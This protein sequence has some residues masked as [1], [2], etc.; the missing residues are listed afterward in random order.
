MNG[1][2]TL[3]WGIN[4]LVGGWLLA[5]CGGVK[6]GLSLFEKQKYESARKKL[7]KIIAKDSLPVG[8]YYLYSQLYTDLAYVG[9][10][11][12]TAYQ[13]AQQAIA[14]YPQL[15]EKQ[16]KKL[17]KQ[18][19][20]DTVR[21]QEQ[22]LRIDSLAFARATRLHQPAAYQRFINDYPSA[23]QLSQAI[24]RRNQ[25]AFDSIRQVDTYPAYKYFMETY[26]EAEQYPQAQ[27]R[28]NTLAFQKLTQEGNLNSYLAFLENYPRSPYRPQAEQAIFEISTAGNQL[29]SY[30]TFARQYPRSPSARKA[31]NLLY[32]LYT[33]AYPADTFL[34]DFP[35]LPYADSLRQAIR[36]E[37]RTL[38]P[39]LKN[40]RYGLID[41]RGRAVTDA[42]FDYLPSA[43]F[44][45]GVPTDFVHTATRKGDELFHTVLTKAGTPVFSITQSLNSSTVGID[46]A[47]TDLGAGLLEVTTDRYAVWHKGGFPIVAAAEKAEEAVLVSSD[48]QANATG[49]V[50]YQFIKFRV[51]N[52]WG[53]KAF[54]GKTLLKP[55]YESV[56]AYGPFLVLERDGLLAVTNRSTVADPLGSPPAATDFIYDDVALLENG[57]LL[58]YRGEQEAVLDEQLDAV[59][60]LGDFRVVRRVAGDSSTTDRWLLKQ[61]DTIQRVVNDS[62]VAQPQTS[63]LLS[64]S[65]SPVRFREAFYNDRWLALRDKEKFVL[66]GSADSIQVAYDSVQILGESFVL[67]VEETKPDSMVVLLAN[68]TH[69]TFSYRPN[70]SGRE[71][72]TF[73]LLRARGVLSP[74]QLQEYLLVNPINELPLIINARGETVYQQALTE[75]TVYPRGLIAIDRG[76]SQ[77]LI[78]SLGQERLPFRYEGI[79][80]YQAPGLLS[81]F[82]NKKFGLYQ[83]PSGTVIEPQYESALTLYSASDSAAQSLFVAKENGKYG[84][85]TA[86]NQARA[87]FAF[88]RVVYWNDT[89]VLAKADDRWLIYGLTEQVKDRAQLDLDR[90]FYGG[91]EDF[92]FFREGEEEQLLRFYAGNS[93]GVL[94]SQ[95]G[96]VLPPSFDSILLLGDATGEDY[97]YFTE[98]YFSE[99]DLY[100]MLYQ[101]AAG[102]LVKRLALTAE[103]YDRLYCDGY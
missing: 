62:L 94:S 61:T 78:D 48:E 29:E 96:E 64:P 1:R 100:I 81:L 45:E 97:L 41:A 44:C 49:T 60:P 91:I 73:R 84:V 51:G 55:T 39:V 14:D 30:A 72:P 68:G 23:S 18:L 92:S 42:R 38:A 77:G 16:Q 80:N 25:L 99:A 89:S 4:L 13:Y 8:A 52:Q 36:L 2:T 32:H 75:A 103:Q 65:E 11:I 7:N 53:I 34:P 82:R 3:R 19:E 5:A 43:Y 20:L 50:P 66:L 102:Q 40:D 88:E 63:Y 56:E 76:R 33:A 12:D 69:R 46:E 98:K 67:T 87:P 22:K 93:Y 79:A 95:R 74:G 37:A 9:Y 47:V 90:V 35:N 24:A 71:E 85:V 31:V 54:S 83:Y 17:Y 86:T 10:D 101:D 27:Q 70:S 59:V 21:L 57:Y 28:Y 58:A 15:A 6:S 26:P